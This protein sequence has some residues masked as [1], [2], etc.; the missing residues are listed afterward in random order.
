MLYTTPWAGVEITS[1]VVG[2]GCQGSYKSSYYAIMTAPFLI[3]D[4][5]TGFGGKYG[6]QTDRVDKSAV[7]YDHKEKLG[8]HESQK[9]I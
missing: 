8:Q 2:T 4:Y 5:S 1:V 7:G 3:L 9:G 6:V